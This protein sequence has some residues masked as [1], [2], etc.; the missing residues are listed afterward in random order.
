MAER[1]NKFLNATNGNVNLRDL[2][3]RINEDITKEGHRVTLKTEKQVEDIDINLIDE[4]EKNE[5]MFGYNNLDDIKKSI[6]QTGTQGVTINVF[7]CD[8]GRYVC[9]SGNTR[10]KAMRDLGE[11]KIT[12]IIEG[13]VPDDH[14][15]MI[16]AIRGNTQREFDPYHIAKEI[17]SLEA[18][19]REKGLSGQVLTEEIESVTGFKLTSQK[20]YKQ[21]LKLSPDLQSLFNCPTIPY[22]KLLKVCK[23][24]PESKVGHFVTQFRK[25]LQDNEPSGELID[26]VYDEV[27]KEDN[28]T[29]TPSVNAI[30]QV[31]LSKAFKPILNLISDEDGNYFVP[32]SKKESYLRQVALLEE[33]LNK[34]K[35]ACGCSEKIGS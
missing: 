35:I 6:S 14:E 24:L 12:C 4:Y 9:Y 1:V 22:Q 23:N 11:K 13:P 33:E 3:S 32:E 5:D 8:N 17:E 25:L 2:T 34:I 26:H 30:T 29:F 15:L 20:L 19:F 7:S 10:L 28:Q 27:M 16:R 31:K 18:S 21:I